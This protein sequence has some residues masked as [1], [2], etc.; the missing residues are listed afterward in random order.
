M[1]RFSSWRLEFLL[2]GQ[3]FHV[4]AIAADARQAVLK[5]QHG[6]V[7]GLNR[8]PLDGPLAPPAMKRDVF[9]YAARCREIGTVEFSDLDVSCKR[10][11]ELLRYLFLCEWPCDQHHDQGANDCARNDERDDLGPARDVFPAACLRRLERGF[12]VHR[13]ARHNYMTPRLRKLTHV[14]IGGSTADKAKATLVDF[15]SAGL[16]F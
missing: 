13:Y 9:G 8:E 3:H 11:A 10:L 2:V 12:L 16:K 5:G 15:S 1:P 14:R 6:G 7:V 4:Q